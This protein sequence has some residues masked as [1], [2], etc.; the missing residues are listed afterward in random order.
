MCR[1]GT[2]L[3]KFFLYKF[4]Q[5][6]VGYFLLAAV[7]T[8]LLAFVFDYLDSSGSRHVYLTFI[9][10]I[11]KTAIAQVIEVVALLAVIYCAIRFILGFFIDK[12][13]RKSAEL[14][15]IEKL[16]TQI[17]K[18]PKAIAKAIKKPNNT[19]TGNKA[20]GKARKR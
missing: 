11:I 17:N 13:A 18:L 5:Q 10:Q 2:Y 12:E 20:K 14:K 4:T 7:F 16:I 8:G 1:L 15:A 6:Q 9:P 19:D 3:K